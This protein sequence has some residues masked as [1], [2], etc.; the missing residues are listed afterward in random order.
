MAVKK[1]VCP[2]CGAPLTHKEG[3]NKVVCEYCG[4]VS[5]IEDEKKNDREQVLQ[6]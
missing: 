4:Y 3:S 1:L 2:G 6:L 5:L